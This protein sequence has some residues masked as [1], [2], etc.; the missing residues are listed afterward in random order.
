MTENEKIDQMVD[1]LG[2]SIAE[3]KEVL[4]YDIAVDKAKAKDKLAY[5]LTAEQE[6]Y[7]KKYRNTPNHKTTGGYQWTTRKR[8]EN[9]T[10]KGIIAELNEFLTERGYENLEILNEERQIG[11]NVGEKRYELTLVEKRKPK[12]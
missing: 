3:A 6:K 4:A 9:T 11:F 2:C 8:K 7:A 1:S 12:K 10:K 5:D